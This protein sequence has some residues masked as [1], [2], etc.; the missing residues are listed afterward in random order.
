MKDGSDEQILAFEKIC[1]LGDYHNNCNVLVVGEGEL[2]VVRK[3]SKPTSQAKFLPCPHCFVFS[4]GD[5]LWRH[6][7]IY[8]QKTATNEKQ[9]WKKVQAEAKLPLPTCS[10]STP[11][12]DAHLCKNVISSPRNDTNSSVA[13]RDQLITTFGAAILEKVGIKNANYVSQAPPSE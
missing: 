2:I 4:K 7:L 9:N 3:P 11:D 5:E 12:V 1:L 6:C 8:L 10:V 13:R